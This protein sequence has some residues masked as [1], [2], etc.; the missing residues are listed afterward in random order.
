LSARWYLPGV[1]VPSETAFAQKPD[2]IAPVTNLL[3]ARQP[4][5]RR[6]QRGLV[7]L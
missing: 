5:L 6:G 7:P 2:D 3:A 1:L 4:L